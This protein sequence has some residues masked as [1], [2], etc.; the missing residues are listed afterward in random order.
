MG[1]CRPESRLW[2]NPLLQACT[3]IRTQS[4]IVI[5][6]NALHQRWFFGKMF[7]WFS[8]DISPFSLSN[9]RSGPSIERVFTP[10]PDT[11]WLKLI[12]G[13]AKTGRSRGALLYKTC[14]GIGQVFRHHLLAKVNTRS[15]CQGLAQ[16][17]LLILSP[18][19]QTVSAAQTLSG[20]TFDTFSYSILLLPIKNLK[21]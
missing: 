6:M 1:V 15:G 13:K 12:L 18:A 2:L 4:G 20:K 3:L 5:A 16:I 14:F 8:D 11:V 9:K 17:V 7:F 10:Q 19:Q 21:L